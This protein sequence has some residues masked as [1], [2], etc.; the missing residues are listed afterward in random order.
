M[1]VLRQLKHKTKKSAFITTFDLD[2]SSF[3]SELQFFSINI[4][5]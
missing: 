4:K 2:M 1:L 3:C 5:A